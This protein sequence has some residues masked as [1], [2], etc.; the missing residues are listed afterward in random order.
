LRRKMLKLCCG[1]PFVERQ[2]QYKRLS[3]TS[4]IT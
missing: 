2:P 1:I 4:K 3:C